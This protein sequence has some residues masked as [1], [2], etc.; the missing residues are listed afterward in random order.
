M[1]YGSVI[2]LKR[3]CRSQT[4]WY[5]TRVVTF[6]GEDKGHATHTKISS[7]PVIAL[8][9]KRPFK[10]KDKFIYLAPWLVT[11]NA[12]SVH[13]NERREAPHRRFAVYRDTR[14]RLPPG[15]CMGGERCTS[16]VPQ[17]RTFNTPEPPLTGGSPPLSPPGGPRI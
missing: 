14:H 8:I 13:R 2:F 5:Q 4:F 10:I 12:S 9:F 15:G 7:Y 16:S 17:P 11:G 6:T 1:L 3:L